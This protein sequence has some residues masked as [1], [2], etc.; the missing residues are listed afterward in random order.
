MSKIYPQAE[1][2]IRTGYLIVGA[3]LAGC[4]LGYLLRKA[5][6][7]VMALERYD[8]LNKDKLCAGA[9]VEKTFKLLAG[10]F[11]EDVREALH[12]AYINGIRLRLKGLE[13]RR[14]NV[15]GMIAMP[16]K[17]L[18]DYAL[19]RYL[20]AGGKLLD[21]V[22]VK[23]VDSVT[24]EAICENL[25]TG[26]RFTIHFETIIGT[27]GAASSVRRL[28]TGKKPA[29]IPC[30]EAQVPK[31]SNEILM[32][33]Q[34]GKVGYAWYIPQTEHATVGAGFWNSTTAFCR[35]S[36]HSFLQEISLNV[37]SRAIRGAF[38]PSGDDILLHV[39][40]N[41]Y[42]AGDAAGLIH[43]MS[44]AGIHYALFSAKCLAKA[45]TG[46]TGYEDAMSPWTEEI[47]GMAGKATEI[48][49]IRN[50]SIYAKGV[51]AKPL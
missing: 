17:Q 28:I 21:R 9:M 29:V 4:T 13:L 34:F 15:H 7:D 23:V 48:Q 47:T 5:G 27:D 30:F 37:D 33:Y 31:I 10:I 24:R 42:F 44:G 25:R 41:A 20:N 49:F 22:S 12:P 14:N 16:R 1:N 35:E 6:A 18:D 26:R 11:G 39:G 3:G 46:G 2:S 36:L 19:C 51:P 43:P 45:L 40:E 32:T 50:Y 38:L 8:A